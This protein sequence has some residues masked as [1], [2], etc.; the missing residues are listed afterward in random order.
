MFCSQVGFRG[1]PGSR[2]HCSS[3][4]GKHDGN[5]GA[6]LPEVCNSLNPGAGTKAVGGR[7]M[8]D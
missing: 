6:P 7:A 5:T 1:L 4:W 3:C 8:A 2:T